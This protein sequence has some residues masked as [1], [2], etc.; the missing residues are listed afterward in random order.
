MTYTGPARPTD[1]NVACLGQFQ[2]VLICRRFPMRAHAAPRE[3]DHRTG[4]CVAIGRVRNSRCSANDTR[5]HRLTSVEDLDVKPFRC[6]A[7]GCEAL[8]HVSHEA[9]RPAKV[10]V[11]VS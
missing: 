3:E 1:W 2:N 8:L 7:E 11:R 4:V 6:Y 10:D 5:G 9:S